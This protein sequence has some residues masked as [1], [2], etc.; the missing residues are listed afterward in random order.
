MDNKRAEQPD[1]ERLLQDE[2]NYQDLK[3]EKDI[4]GGLDKYYMDPAWMYLQKY[5]NRVIGDIRGK[6]VLDLGCG[7][8]GATL[9][10]LRR[11][12]Y[13]TAVDISPKSIE[14]V[15]EE[16]RKAGTD[17][18]L[19]AYVMDAQSLD[20]ED[21]AF[22]V[23]IGNGILHHLP[24]LEESL[25]EIQRVLKEDGHAVF[26]EPL[27]INPLLNLYRLLTPSMRTKDEQ[28]FRMKEIRLIKNVFPKAEFVFFDFT[29]PFSK[30][31]MM[32]RLPNLA[33]RL[34][35]KLI[36]TDTL[37]IRKKKRTRI[38]LLQ[39]MSWNVVIKLKS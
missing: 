29:T 24:F 14:V 39:K 6:K 26:V 18:A 20:L 5:K 10:A 35:N 16:A 32:I 1:R 28:P 11:G 3:V 17:G 19:S 37:L 36:K 8:G 33:M 31:L 4:R 21:H 15:K 30:F 23:V 13:V 38:S 22:D 9:D 27:G 7:K 25:R 12:A 2:A 34:Q